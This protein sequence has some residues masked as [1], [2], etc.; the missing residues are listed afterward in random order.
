[1]L[2]NTEST[3]YDSNK[4][5]IKRAALVRIPTLKD[6]ALLAYSVVIVYLPDEPGIEWGLNE[7]MEHNQWGLTGESK[8]GK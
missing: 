5:E 2:L 6:S 4:T 8:F 7:I 3:Y 1:M